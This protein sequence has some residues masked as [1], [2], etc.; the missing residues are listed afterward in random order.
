MFLPEPEPIAVFCTPVEH[1]ERLAKPTAVLLPGTAAVLVKS[2]KL[3]VPTAVLLREVVRLSR[4]RYPKPT[5]PVAVVREIPAFTPPK[6]FK[7][8]VV[9][10]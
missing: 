2:L 8:V 6:T 10:L 1:C 5:H 7:L 9:R 3:S 4:E